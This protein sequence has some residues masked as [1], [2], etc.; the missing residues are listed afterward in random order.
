MTTNP[1]RERG[2][3]ALPKDKQKVKINITIDR[4]LLDWIDQY[5]TNRSRA[6][7]KV[8]REAHAP[9]G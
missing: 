7:N 4:D 1:P 8:L 6:I 5:G 3:P 9:R 2:R